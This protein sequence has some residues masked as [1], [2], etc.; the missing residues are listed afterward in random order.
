[1]GETGQPSTPKKLEALLEGL[2]DKDEDV[3]REAALALGEMG[4]AAARPEVIQALLERLRDKYGDVRAAAALA[5]GWMGKAAA[6]P[7]VLQALR[8]R[9]R[10]DKKEYVREAA[11]E[12][13]G[14]M[15]EAED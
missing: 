3:R 10:I 8:E 5:L 15:E 12:A 4:E 9:L 11:A 14:K 7:E 2:R 13:L 1:M 6:T